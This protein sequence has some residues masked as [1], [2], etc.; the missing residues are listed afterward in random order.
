MIFLAVG[1]ETTAPATAVAIVEAQ[2]KGLKNVFFLCGHKLVVP[3]MLALLSQG[4][5]GG[6]GL[7]GFLCPGHVSVIIGARAYQP[8]VQSYRNP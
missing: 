1:F 6:A 2:Q 8:V 5:P 4:D 7:D 3:A